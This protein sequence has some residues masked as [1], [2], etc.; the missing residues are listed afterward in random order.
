MKILDCVLGYTCRLANKIYV[1]AN[2][3]EFL[4]RHRSSSGSSEEGGSAGSRSLS[5][6]LNGKQAHIAAVISDIYNDHNVTIKKEEIIL[7]DDDINNVRIAS[8]FGHYAFQVQQNVDYSSF[9]NFE[10]MLLV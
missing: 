7:M 8:S 4:Q 2:T 3:S 9:V 5:S 10:T 1:Q 6:D